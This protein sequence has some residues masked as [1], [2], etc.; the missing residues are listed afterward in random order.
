ML[1]VPAGEISPDPEYIL[2]TSADGGM[3]SL[4]SDERSAEVFT[5]DRA[6]KILG[7]QRWMFQNAE[8]VPAT[9][10]DWIEQNQVHA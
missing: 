9:F 2:S 4:T 7:Q 1:L 3:V 6:G 5:E 8:L 10:A